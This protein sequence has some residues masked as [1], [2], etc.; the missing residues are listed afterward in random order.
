M[1]VTEGNRGDERGTSE[2]ERRGDDS[3]RV[4]ERE[5]RTHR[6]VTSDGGRLVSFPRYASL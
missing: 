5:E 1:T 6:H 3:Y 2:R 4:K